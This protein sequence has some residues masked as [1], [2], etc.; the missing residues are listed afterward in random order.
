[1]E[2]TAQ[3]VDSGIAA[4]VECVTVKFMWMLLHILWT[5]LL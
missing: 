5:M 4:S 2:G 1:M 3:H